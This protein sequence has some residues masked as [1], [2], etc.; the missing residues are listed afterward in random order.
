MAKDV[1]VEAIDDVASAVH[2]NVSDQE[3]LLVELAQVRQERIEGVPLGEALGGPVRP[4][5]LVILDRIVNRLTLGSA[6]LRRA[7]I[8]SLVKDGESVTS[9]ATRFEVTHQRISSILRRGKD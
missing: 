7:L 4:R 9:V 5:A 1:V 2:E 6:R 8:T 3:D